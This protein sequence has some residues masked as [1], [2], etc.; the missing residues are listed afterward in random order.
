[1]ATPQL[2][3]RAFKLGQMQ[4]IGSGWDVVSCDWIRKKGG[5]S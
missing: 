4:V 3:E 2:Y 1:M 5:L